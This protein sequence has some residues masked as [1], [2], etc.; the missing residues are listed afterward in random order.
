M[1]AS[2][3]TGLRISAD[4]PTAVFSKALSPVLPQGE[5]WTVHFVAG[6]SLMF[7]LTAYVIYIARSGLAE[8]NALRRVTAVTLPGSSPAAR[9]AR[10]GAINV[11]LHW[12]IYGLVILMTGTGIALY[13][14]FGGWI[15]TVHAASALIRS[16]TSS[17]T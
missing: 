7:S 1:I 16:P 4:A 5:I 11:A 6:L 2:L 14:G 8:R 10:W 15:V 13:L 3:L 17:S 9:K 12:F